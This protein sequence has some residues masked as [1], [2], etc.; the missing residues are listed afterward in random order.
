VHCQAVV[1]GLLTARVVILKHRP[2]P[3][4]VHRLVNDHL[5]RPRGLERDRNIVLNDEPP[6]EGD[7][8]V[9]LRS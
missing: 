6:I 1:V 9:D 5:L 2:R 7:G 3:P 8:D 4:K